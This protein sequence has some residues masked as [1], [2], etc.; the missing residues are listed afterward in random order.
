M[1]VSPVLL[2]NVSAE[3]AD[4]VYLIKEEDPSDPIQRLMTFYVSTPELRGQVTF[5]PQ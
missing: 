1:K 3:G 2:T 5:T 4:P